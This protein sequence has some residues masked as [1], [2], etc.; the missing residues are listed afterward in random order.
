MKLSRDLKIAAALALG[1]TTA[2]AAWAQSMK[3]E[4]AIKGRQASASAPSVALAMPATSTSEAVSTASTLPNS[5]LVRSTAVPPSET[6]ST[7]AAS[8]IRKKPA[9]LALLPSFSRA[10]LLKTKRFLRKVMSWELRR[11]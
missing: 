8:A 2:G 3:P 4:S 7:P 5:K 9:R 10:D 6:I 11:C 1:L